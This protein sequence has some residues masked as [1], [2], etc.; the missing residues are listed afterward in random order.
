M[1]LVS[2]PPHKSM[3]PMCYYTTDYGQEYK[4]EVAYSQER[5]EAYYPCH[6]SS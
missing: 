6:I 2:L 3:R 1:A 5:Q 4:R